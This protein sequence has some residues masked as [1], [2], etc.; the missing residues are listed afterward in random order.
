MGSTPKKLLFICGTR[1]EG[2][3]VAPVI[4]AFARHPERYAVKLCVTGQHRQ[5]LQQTLDFFELRPDYDLELMKP[6]QTLFEV[7]AGALTGL[8]PILT[9]DRPDM[10]FV[11]GDTTTAFAGALASFYEKIPVAHI[12]AGL[13]THERYSP[14]PE[15]V[16]RALI[17]KVAQLHFAPT[18][19][20]AENL[21]R[22]GIHENVFQ[23]GNTVIDALLMSLERVRGKHASSFAA[24]FPFV[25]PGRRMILVTGHRRESFGKP[26]EAICR[27]LRSLV[28]RYPDVELVYP[29]H[30]NP[31][32]RGPVGEILRGVERVHL[33]EP[34]EYPKLVWLMS[35]SHLVLTDSGGI[36]EE[37]PSLGKPVLVMRE[38]T[39]RPEGIDAGCARLVGTTEAG[40]VEGVS[41]LLTDEDVYRRMAQAKNPYGDG[42]SSSAIVR[43]VDA[44]LG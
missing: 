25:R 23:V 18:R 44:A 14:F 26:F 12:E 35:Q 17:S 36:Q 21:A 40:I 43:H 10:V 29:V 32:V 13:R 42:T 38:V 8:A 9:K 39:E 6:G 3:K 27:A 20:A 37:A 34:V 22:E 15:E 2:I 16:N 28:E 31:N 1:P 7:T 30:L 11:Q 19:A 41:Q 5:M 33:L 24:E 4:Q